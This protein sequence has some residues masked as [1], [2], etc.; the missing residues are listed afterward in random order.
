[1]LLALAQQR[2]NAPGTPLSWDRLLQLAWPKRVA[3][4]SDGIRVRISISRLRALGLRDVLWSS[5]SGYW[6]DPAIPLDL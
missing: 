6:L 4:G 5:S 3:S 2:L 1:V